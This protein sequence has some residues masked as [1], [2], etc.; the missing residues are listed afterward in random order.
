VQE[1]YH[2]CLCRPD[3]WRFLYH[4]DNGSTMRYSSS[5]NEMGPLGSYR[6]E[7]REG[8]V[9]IQQQTLLRRHYGKL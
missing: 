1:I 3:E 7:M 2:L 8:K 5:L 6:L 4:G 9:T